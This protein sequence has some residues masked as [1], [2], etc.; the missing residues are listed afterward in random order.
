MMLVER[1]S[2]RN[3]AL[4]AIS[5]Y[6]R[7]S[8]EVCSSE[9]LWNLHNNA[10]SSSRTKEPV[11]EPSA[12]DSSDTSSKDRVGI[13]GSIIP[14]VYGRVGQGNV[15]PSRV[16]SQAEV[17][18]LVPLS[19]QYPPETDGFIRATSNVMEFNEDTRSYFL[20]SGA[21]LGLKEISDINQLHPIL[22]A[23]W[24]ALH[25]PKR[26]LI[27]VR[28]KDENS[29]A[30][31]PASR[32]CLQCSS[33]LTLIAPR[34]ENSVEVPVPA[35]SICPR[36][37][38][39]PGRLNMGVTSGP[40]PG[41][42]IR[43]GQ[44]PVQLIAWKRQGHFAACQ[45][46]IS[47]I[48]RK[49]EDVPMAEGGT[50]ECTNGS[51]WGSKCHLS[52]RSG[53]VLHGDSTIV[54]DGNERKVFWSSP[55]PQCKSRYFRKLKSETSPKSVVAKLPCLKPKQPKNGAVVCDSN[56]K[57]L[58]PDGSVCQFF[59]YPGFLIEQEST[60][61]ALT[62]C[63]NGHWTPNDDLTCVAAYCSEPKSPRDSTLRCDPSENKDGLSKSKYKNGTRCDFRCGIGTKIPKSQQA[64]SFIVCNAPHW[65]D[66]SIPECKRF[67]YPKHHKDDC[68]NQTLFV[69]V[70]EDALLSSHHIPRFISHDGKYL[71][72]TCSLDG[73]RLPK[74]VHHNFCHANDDEFEVAS[75]CRYHIHV[76]EKIS[77]RVYP[78]DC[79]DIDRVANRKGILHVKPPKFVFQNG[80]TKRILRGN[81]THAGKLSVGLYQN[82]C[83]AYDPELDATGFCSY[84]INIR[85]R[86]CPPPIS[87]P[88]A[89]IQC[90]NKIDE[91]YSPKTVCKY[92]CDE[93][94]TIPLKESNRRSIRCHRNLSWKPASVP[95]CKKAIPPRPKRNECVSQSFFIDKDTSMATIRQPRFKSSLKGSK[96]K[97][98][99][100]LNNTLPVGNYTNVCEAL[101]KELGLKASCKYN[102][103]I[104][105]EGCEALPTVSFGFLNCSSE[106]G[107]S[108][109]LPINSICRYD[110]HDGYT[111]TTSQLAFSCKMCH[112]DGHWNSTINP[113]CVSKTPP[114]PKQDSCI[115][116]TILEADLERFD[117]P[118]PEFDS[119]SGAKLD[120]TCIPSNVS[121]YDV[122]NISCT[123][124]DPQLRVSSTCSFKLDLQ[125]P[126]DIAELDREEIACA[127]LPI[128]PNGHV[129][130]NSSEAEH[131]S[132]KTICRV[133]CDDGF[134]IPKS[135]RALSTAMCTLDSQWNVT[136][137]P[138]CEKAAPPIGNPGCTDQRLNITNLKEISVPVPSFLT[139]RNTPSKVSCYPEF[140]TNFGEHNIACKATDEELETIFEC[141]YN[142]EVFEEKEDELTV[143]DL[144]L[145]EDGL[146]PFKP[147]VSIA[148]PH[149]GALNCTDD[150][151][152]EI[153]A[154]RC[155]EGYGFSS[156]YQDLLQ[157][158]IECDGTDGLWD[159]Q[160]I[161]NTSKFPECLGQLPNTSVEVWISFKALCKDC[162]I[163]P[164]LYEDLKNLLI[165]FNEEM[166][167]LVDCR[168]NLTLNCS[169]EENENVLQVFWTIGTAF[170]PSDFETS[171]ETPE[172]EKQLEIILKTTKDA[173]K[174]DEEFR[175][176]ISKLELQ[177]LQNSF[178]KGFIRLACHERGY[179]ADERTD[180][181]E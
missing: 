170:N 48:V 146:P 45:Y 138:D 178:S 112:L 119:T 31:T 79:K 87:T 26:V 84:R 51:I 38:R 88:H 44:Y 97:V 66:S 111:I 67:I 136:K 39:A 180:K 164:D 134:V 52:C 56:G 121:S 114:T 13:Q 32:G 93:G 94:F 135:L 133:I 86:S 34:G 90:D 36:L 173:I 5:V 103:T 98:K 115:D 174:M 75:T 12:I 70:G 81:C 14:I 50:F 122:H 2:R 10:S 160:R 4:V 54:C 83:T 113:S 127:S 161:Y 142:L 131:I 168:T 144:A 152:K 117:I 159:F 137:F 46:T 77:P 55:F 37:A 126:A 96:I 21:S 33:N 1:F 132:A 177:L 78:K 82:N 7:I 11:R 65:N 157:R 165:S 30:S 104:T 181:C 41:L 130:C 172:V 179:A 25:S 69:E 145:D 6:L 154:V 35:I 116:R 149:N 166:C 91:L 141:S 57:E 20:P 61:N 8:F 105:A 62:V 53:F 107:T 106:L 3:F 169:E 43:E 24:I 167:D 22:N 58:Y 125:N 47:L 100:S 143:D 155:N 72:T 99:C 175:S 101:D 171:G 92:I 74:G 147:C 108:S 89:V 162:D 19:R 27:P 80:G 156:K 68:R 120:I 63:K 150:G 23:S 109:L 129:R 28:H 15:R 153:C 158:G 18:L 128:V 140:V 49:C 151:G 110:C 29:I 9:N 71:K 139:A 60:S 76:Q 95:S 59:C 40:R 17:R 73:Q 16:R 42:R 148:L 123:A 102:V 64:K 85:E 176:E 124:Y 163:K 118:I